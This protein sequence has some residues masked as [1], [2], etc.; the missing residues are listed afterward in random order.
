MEERIMTI[1]D[2][3]TLITRTATAAALIALAARLPQPATGQRADRE[4]LVAANTTFALDLYHE[5]APSAAGNLIISPYSVSLALAMTYAG[6]RHDTAAQ[7]AATLGFDLPDADLHPALAALTSDL[8]RRGNQERDDEE[9]RAASALRIA[10]ALWGERTYP[11]DEDFIEALAAGYDA[12]LELVDYKTDPEQARVD[13]NAW[14][15]EQTE[16]RIQGIVPERAITDL[17]RLVL[18]NAIWFYGAWQHTF[19]ESSTRDEPFHLLDATAVDVPFMIQTETFAYAALDAMQVVDLPYNS[20]GFSM[21][22]I[23]PNDGQ[24]DAV[25]ADLDP[26]MLQDA[27]AGLEDTEIRLF[28]P[29]FEFE[30]AASL[31]ATLQAMGMT[32]AFDP[33]AADFTGMI[34]NGTPPPGENLSIGDVLHKA[35][36]S[37]DEEGTEAAA[38]TVVIMV[39]EGMP[40]PS[41]PPEVRFD[42]PF[43]FAIRDRVS[44][45]ILFL[46]RVTDPRG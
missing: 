23:L 36:I 17:T 26:T 33:Q 9:G 35:F 1:L 27:L 22:L 39:G 8:V 29:K 43:L 42:R 32:D 25:E 41:T 44:G 14:V 45:T 2:R 37:V 10:N 3:R 20:D 19:E 46:G 7:M 18:A 15:E 16:D 4:A 6:A 40:A 31:A 28:L 21:T 34:E 30:Y 12:G 24:F 11:F 13:I 5:L 38:A